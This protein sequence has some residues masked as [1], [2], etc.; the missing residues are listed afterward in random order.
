MTMT[1]QKEL[2]CLLMEVGKKEEAAEVIIVAQVCM[3]SFVQLV[4]YTKTVGIIKTLNENT[5]N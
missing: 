1:I 5:S 2:T 3:F 4:L